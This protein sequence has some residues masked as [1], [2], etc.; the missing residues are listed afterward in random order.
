MKTL[1]FKDFKAKWILEGVKTKEIL[2][3]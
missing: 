3:R 2:W 1:K